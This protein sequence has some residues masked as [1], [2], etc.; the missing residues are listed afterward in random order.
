MFGYVITNCK[1]LS[2]EERLRFRS[3]Y[4]GMCRTLRLRHGNLG[5]LTLSYDMTFLAM[6]LSALY[7]SEE[8]QGK[9]KCMPHPVRPHAYTVNSMMEYAADMNILLA[10][11]K[12]LD[13]VQDEKSLRGQAGEKALRAAYKKVQAKYPQKCENVRMCLEKLSALEKENCADIDAVANLSGQMLA[14]TFA[15]KDDVF[16]PHLRLI[17]AALGKFIYLMD[18]YEDFDQ[19]KKRGRYNPLCEM[20]AQEDYEARM[21]DILTMQMGKCVRE[22]DYLPLEQDAQLLRNI[23]YS[24]VW[25]KY[26]LIQQKRKETDR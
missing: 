20:H 6:V 11:F 22:M 16:A 21:Q 19:D 14:E 4:C 13:D 5:R 2:D 25:G 1:T 8:T 9:E 26:A 18:A 10:Y 15:W 23:L 7:E 3:M 12:C 17:G 24:G